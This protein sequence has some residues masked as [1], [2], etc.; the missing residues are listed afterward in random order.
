VHYLN[1]KSALLVFNG[2]IV[3]EFDMRIEVC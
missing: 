1:T 3:K 2:K